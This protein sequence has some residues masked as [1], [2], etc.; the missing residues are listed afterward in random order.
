MHLDSAAGGSPASIAEAGR[1][2]A[3]GVIWVAER[4]GSH[5]PRAVRA[6][7][8]SSV[9]L[10]P[11]IV[12]WTVPTASL[13]GMVL[14][15]D[16]ACGVSALDAGQAATAASDAPGPGICWEYGEIFGAP[17]VEGAVASF[18]AVILN[19]TTHDEETLFFG[20]LAGFCHSPSRQSAVLQSGLVR[21]VE[22]ID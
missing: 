12:L 2:F 9:S 21:R 20:Q 17:L 16:H 1:L 8:F 15:V 19:R 6:S 14:E 7:A 4:Q 5:R 11:P 10:D 22:R 18:E 13:R 3:S